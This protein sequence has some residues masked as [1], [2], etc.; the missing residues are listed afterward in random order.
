MQANADKYPAEMCRGSSAKYTSY[1]R[2]Y[3]LPHEH[4]PLSS[5]TILHRQLPVL[6]SFFTPVHIP[7][8]LDLNWCSCVL[9]P[10]SAGLPQH[11]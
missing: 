5:S 11:F 9:L 8:M 6:A 10:I 3:A 1:N 4:K 2:G 7:V